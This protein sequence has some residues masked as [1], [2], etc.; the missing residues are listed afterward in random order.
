MLPT[1]S[2]ALIVSVHLFLFFKKALKKIW[3]NI[4]NLKIYMVIKKKFC[5]TVFPKVWSSSCSCQLGMWVLVPNSTCEHYPCCALLCCHFSHV[6]LFSVVACQAPGKNTGV[7]CHALLHM[8]GAPTFCRI[9]PL[10][11]ENC[12]AAGVCVSVPWP[13]RELDLFS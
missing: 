2:R 9:C 4:N 1:R 13:L 7:G 8:W 12:D 3:Q 11:D 6:R 5:Q 10:L